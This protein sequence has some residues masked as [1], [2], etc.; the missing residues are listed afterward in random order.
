[1]DSKKWT[2]KYLLII[3]LV[4]LIVV[5]AAICGH[6]GNFGGLRWFSDGWHNGNVNLQNY[7]FS[8]EKIT[9]VVIDM[10]AADINIQDG[11]EFSIDASFPEKYMPTVEVKNGKLTINQHQSVKNIKNFDDYKLD[12]VVPSAGLD[13]LKID[14][15]AG[16]IDIQNINVKKLDLDANA[17]DIDI[18]DMVADKIT[19]DVNAGDV[20]V[21]DTT[22]KSIEVNA[23][24]GD[25]DITGTYD[26]IDCDC[27]LGDIDIDAPNTDR[28]DIDVDCALG[29]VNVNGNKQK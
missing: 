28:D 21:M 22:S 3:W 15:A 12:I 1:M 19:V 16:D 11:S 13:S 18:N 23:N 5:V 6:I 25:V 2:K 20:D 24:A 27:D 29:S 4:T 8:N 14:I 10:N 9:D 26:K 7:D 17:G